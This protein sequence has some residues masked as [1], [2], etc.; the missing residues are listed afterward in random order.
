MT[1]HGPAISRFGLD[2]LGL[3]P[4]AAHWNLDT[5][6]LYEQALLRGE[7]QLAKDGPLVGV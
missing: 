2:R 4:K 7:A 6:P 1:D 3:A 5:A